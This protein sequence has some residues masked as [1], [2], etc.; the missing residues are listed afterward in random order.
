MAARPV[1]V[2][3]RSA[4]ITRARPPIRETRA[5]RSSS[6]SSTPGSPRSADS[7]RPPFVD[8]AGHHA[9]GLDQQGR[10]P[11]GRA[12]LDDLR[13]VIAAR[14]LRSC[15]LEFLAQRRQPCLVAGFHDLPGEALQLARRQG[16]GIEP[17][18]VLDQERVLTDLAEEMMVLR[19]RRQDQGQ[20]GGPGAVLQHRPVDGAEEPLGVDVDLVLLAALSVMHGHA[21]AAD[22]AVGGDGLM[23]LGELAAQRLGDRARNARRQIDFEQSAPVALEQPDRLEVEAQHLVAVERLQEP[24]Q[25]LGMEAVGDDGQLGDRLREAVGVKDAGAAQHGQPVERVGPEVPIVG[26]RLERFQQ[27]PCLRRGMLAQQRR[28]QFLDEIAKPDRVLLVFGMVAMGRLIER[29]ARAVVDSGQAGHGVAAEGRD[30]LGHAAISSCDC[31]PARRRRFQRF[32]PATWRQTGSNGDCPVSPRSRRACCG[33]LGRGRSWRR[34]FATGKTPAGANRCSDRG[35]CGG[36][37]HRSVA[38]DH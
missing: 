24:P 6:T 11:A 17:D 25:R 30:R 20:A 2:G 14:A 8:P 21:R 10:D 29:Q 12:G 27:Q 38:F 13:Q 7:N 35:P 15:R 31:S 26:E 9:I 1:R 4:G 36:N 34:W 16:I 32:D 5:P 19:Q 28:F 22:A 37:R 23:R 33:Q 3:I 18:P